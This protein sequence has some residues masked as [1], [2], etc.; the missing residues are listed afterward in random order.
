MA[1]FIVFWPYLLTNKLRSVI[2]HNLG[3]SMEYGHMKAKFGDLKFC[4]FSL[5]KI[6]IGW[7]LSCIKVQICKQCYCKLIHSCLLF[8]NLNFDTSYINF[9]LSKEAKKMTFKLGS[10]LNLS[11]EIQSTIFLLIFLDFS[12]N[13]FGKLDLAEVH[14][15]MYSPC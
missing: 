10:S 1:V 5:L 11:I 7:V 13:P 12:I 14:D 8:S 2:R 4:R 9:L 3:H 15:S 6:K